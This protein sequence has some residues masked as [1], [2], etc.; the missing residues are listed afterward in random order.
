MR[1]PLSPGNGQPHDHSS[2]PR[3]P[4]R[5]V[6]AQMA[7]AAAE[8]MSYLVRE[9]VGHLDHPALDAANVQGRQNLEHHH[10]RAS[11]PSSDISP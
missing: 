3:V 1:T 7:W 8:S 11:L 6:L 10:I 4:S 2:H 5:Q 9:M